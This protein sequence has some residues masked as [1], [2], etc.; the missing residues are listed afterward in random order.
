MKLC[1]FQSVFALDALET[2]HPVSIPVGHPDEITE[3]FDL[4]SYYKGASIIRMMDAFLT[5]ES[6]RK[7]L[8]N[9]LN[10]LWVL[11]IVDIFLTL[12]IGTVLLNN[13]RYPHS[14]FLFLFY[15]SLNFVCSQYKAAAQ[16]DLWAHLTSQALKDNTLPK[17]LTVKTIM[18]T[19]TLQKG[20]PVIT[21]T[22]D[23]ESK[24][25]T[26]EQDRFLLVKNPESEDTHDYK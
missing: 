17:D 2:S 10:D 20:F 7:G 16:D 12:I 13:E 19:W 14:I 18:D 4:I 8:T 9:Y 6:F 21:V 11:F 5:T 25:A 1:H 23:Y 3:I 24:S 22:R 26:V 15:N